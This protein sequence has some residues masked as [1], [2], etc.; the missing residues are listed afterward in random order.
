MLDPL[1]S[2]ITVCVTYQKDS[3]KVYFHSYKPKL[4]CARTIEHHSASK[5]LNAKKSIIKHLLNLLACW[6]HFL[7]QPH[8]FFL[9]M[10]AL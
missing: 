10:A 9:M 8:C 5:Q 7:Y 3:R 6:S 4:N 2:Q 1:P